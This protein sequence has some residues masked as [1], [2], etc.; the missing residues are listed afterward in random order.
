MQFLLESGW[1]QSASGM[2]LVL[3]HLLSAPF[4]PWNGSAPL[5]GYFQRIPKFSVCQRKGALHI[6]RKANYKEFVCTE[7]RLS[8]ALTEVVQWGSAWVDLVWEVPVSHS[9]QLRTGLWQMRDCHSSLFSHSYFH[10]FLFFFLH[11]YF[12]VLV[13][14]FYCSGWALI[15]KKDLQSSSLSWEQTDNF[16]SSL[17]F[18]V[19]IRG[20][21]GLLALASCRACLRSRAACCTLWAVLRALVVQ[22]RSSAAV[23]GCANFPLTAISM[24]APLMPWWL[25]QCA[26]SRS[27]FLFH[28]SFPPFKGCMK[29]QA[30]RSEFAVLCFW[31]L[32]L[33]IFWFFNLT[34]PRS[35]FLIHFSSF[36]TVKS[37]SHGKSR[38]RF[39][40]G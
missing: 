18:M 6:R 13:C 7:S 12:Q 2:C 38:E 27:C 36:S 14:I 26:Y 28:F 30:S 40:G 25:L 39:W 24:A 10:P 29:V 11:V 22:K 19:T 16:F 35:Y 3:C 20:G 31:H 21:A 23:P 15:K 34:K 37:A 17:E 33:L 1:E 8:I 32:D 4:K 5:Y 9:K